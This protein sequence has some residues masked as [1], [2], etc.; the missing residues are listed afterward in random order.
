VDA[1]SLRAHLLRILHDG[2]D[3][4]RHAPPVEEG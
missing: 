3:L 1:P 4:A 2:M